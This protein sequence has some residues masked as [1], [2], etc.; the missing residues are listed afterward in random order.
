MHN[1]FVLGVLVVVIGGLVGWYVVKGDFRSGQHGTP[2]STT[3]DVQQASETGTMQEG[4]MVSE[5]TTEGKMTVEYTDGGFSPDMVRI[6]NGTTVTFTNQS[7][8]TMWV[9]S[10]AHPTH[11][12]L[13]GFDSRKSI[14]TGGSYE[15]TFTKIGTWTYHN[16]VSPSAVGTV[17]VSD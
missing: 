17:V 13:P 5:A 16:H 9:A 4:D 14:L 3:E 7:T 10:D 12:L 15:Y 1:T 6:K 8:G 11:Q 2:V